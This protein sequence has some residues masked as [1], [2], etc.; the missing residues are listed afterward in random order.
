MTGCK[1]R[2]SLW[3]QEGVLIMLCVLNHM[4][5]SVNELGSQCDLFYLIGVT[6]LRLSSPASFHHCE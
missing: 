4:L 1:V 2:K 3:L 6:Y 5:V